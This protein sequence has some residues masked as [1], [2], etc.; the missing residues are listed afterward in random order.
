MRT[1]SIL[2]S[3]VLSCHVSREDSVRGTRDVW[4]MFVGSGIRGVSTNIG[5][6]GG[7]GASEEEG[8]EGS[9]WLIISRCDCDGSLRAR[10]SVGR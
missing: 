2:K 10:L 1:V 7:T 5:L 3:R 4:R 9:M 6:L 8:G